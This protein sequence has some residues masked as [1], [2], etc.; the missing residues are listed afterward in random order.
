MS[1]RIYQP[2]PAVLG[3]SWKPPPIEPVG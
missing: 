3:G 1:L 2:T